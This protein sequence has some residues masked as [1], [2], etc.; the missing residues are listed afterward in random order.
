MNIKP[1][2]MPLLT[3][4]VV[5]F[6]GGLN[7][8]VSSIQLGSGELST[9]VNYHEVAGSSSGYTS[10]AGFERVDGRESAS[11]V[12]VITEV[13]KGLDGNVKLLLE[14]DSGLV[15]LSQQANVISSSGA[16]LTSTRYKNGLSSYCLAADGNITLTHY[17]SLSLASSFCM[18]LSLYP[19]DVTVNR[20][21]FEKVGEYKLEL[22]SS[23]L[24]F[25]C[26]TNGTTYNV[27]VSSGVLVSNKWV[28]FSV[29]KS[30]SNLFIAI[31][32]TLGTPVV[33]SD[34]LI[35][36]TSNLVI[37][38]AVS[39]ELDQL[40]LSDNIRYSINYPV[41]VRLFSSERYYT[42]L[43]DD[44]ARE[45]QRALIL[46]LPGAGKV[47]GV[48]FFN[49]TIYGWREDLGVDP[50][51][52]VMY[53]STAAGW[54]EVV[55]PDGY[56]FNPLGNVFTIEYRFESF[57]LNAPILSIVD[58]VSVP[59]LFDG[60]TITILTS[61][62]LPD[63]SVSPKFASICGAYDNRLFLGYSQGS[64]IFSDVGN[65]VNY[66]SIITSAGEYFLGSPITNIVEA[67]GNTLVI[68][69]D[70]F[71]KIV[72]SVLF[73]DSLWTFQV[74]SFS[75]TQGS[76]KNT[77]RS[78][79]GTVFFCDY[80]GVV[81]LASSDT[82]GSMVSAVI[83]DKITNTYRKSRDSIIGAIID[84]HKNQYQIYLSTGDVIVITF[85][86]DRKVKGVTILSY[87]V[88]MSYI[89]SGKNTA[90]DTIKFFVSSTGYIYQLDS[91]TSFD[92]QVIETQLITSYHH[93][94]SP[95]TWKH[96][97]RIAMEG[98][99]DN[100]IVIMVRL[101]Y[102]YS[103]SSFPRTQL[104]SG[105]VDSIASVYGEAK[106]GSF[107]WG[108]V[109]AKRMVLY[110]AGSGTNAAFELRTSS[111]YKTSHTINNFIVDFTRGAKQV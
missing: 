43:V 70:S 19:L 41:P 10:V 66:S 76:K 55:Q 69:C 92:G 81:S 64:V 2:S 97:K 8:E 29:Q 3:Q 101:L 27:S 37:G 46:P 50:T 36:K 20:V 82:Y 104:I 49:D 62:Q 88:T 75:R 87:N 53:K 32:G 67:P 65:P 21:I 26:S 80:K 85:N 30:G 96:F 11:S 71:I 60:T 5:S 106:W 86:L 23:S 95:R 105:V 100:G 45:A 54:V 31:D 59:R 98:T 15:D 102:D 17:T 14:A 109:P 79:L 9:C 44:A 39:F 89:T 18:E 111:K 13:D 68:T 52:S 56:N 6:T 61:A 24:V 35:T 107:I 84:D 72:K 16:T 73:E 1:V 7:E 40:R 110:V 78:L 77:A 48:A 108:A 51:K 83:T 99:G 93:Y 42:E 47:N 90:G 57:S 91:G 25:S 58:G 103:E 28:D 74:E 34:P 22:V 94:K 63:N 12:A 38:G 4:E 33:V